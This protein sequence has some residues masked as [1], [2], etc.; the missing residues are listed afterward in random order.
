V[1]LFNGREDHSSLPASVALGL[2]NRDDRLAWCTGTFISDDLVVTASHCLAPEI[3]EIYYA[4]TTEAVK[5]GAGTLA[6]EWIPNPGHIKGKD[7]VPQDYGVV[8]FPKGSFSGQA[9]SLATTSPSKGETVSVV[10]YGYSEFKGFNELQ[11]MGKRMVGTAVLGDVGEAIQWSAKPGDTST[12]MNLPGDSGGPVYNSQ[13]ELAGIISH[14]ELDTDMDSGQWVEMRAYAANLTTSQAAS[15]IL[16]HRTG[17]SPGGDAA[18]GNTPDNN[19]SGGANPGGESVGGYSC[20]QQ[21]AWG[22]CGEPWMQPVC[23]SVCGRPGSGSGGDI[24][25]G[26]EASGNPVPSNEDSGNPAPSTSPGVP[27]VG[28]YSCEQQKAWGKCGEPWMRP[29]CDDVCASGG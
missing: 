18:P 13:G 15:F 7:G 19:S 8:R 4:A 1:K 2:V 17:G 25:T 16:S 14:R 28:G 10:G 27:G 26:N 12:A 9:A 5:S 23:D 20:E 21:K 29:V 22:K 11:G 6:S 3:K 24:A